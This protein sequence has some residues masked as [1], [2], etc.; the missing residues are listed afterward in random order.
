MVER[1]GKERESSVV[2]HHH[3]LALPLGVGAK[4]DEHRI[5]RRFA[6]SIH[7]AFVV[8]H[9]LAADLLRTAIVVGVFIERRG[10]TAVTE[11]DDRLILRQTAPCRQLHLARTLTD[12]A[13]V[14]DQ[15]VCLDRNHRLGAG[16]I[17][18]IQFQYTEG[19]DHRR[20]EVYVL[21]FGVE[22]CVA[23]ES[24]ANRVVQ[25]ACSRTAR[26]T[27][28]RRGARRGALRCLQEDVVRPVMLVGLCLHKKTVTS[29][30]LAVQRTC[31]RNRA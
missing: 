14:A 18:G 17:L 15:G 2:D 11:L 1:V 21:V 23:V 26:R 30:I 24:H 27:A 7:F 19:L 25:E 31:L 28:P 3:I 20:F 5:E 29:H 4:L 22:T 16:V 6:R 12:Q 10:L 9:A 13:V 8:R